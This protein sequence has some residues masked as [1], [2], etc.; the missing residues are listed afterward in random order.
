[1]KKNRM[2]ANIFFILLI[3]TKYTSISHSQS[4]EVLYFLDYCSTINSKYINPIYNPYKILSYES[5]YIRTDSIPNGKTLA[6][7]NKIISYAQLDT[8]GRYIF[9][10]EKSSSSVYRLEIDTSC[11]M[12]SDRTINE[13]ARE[14]GYLNLNPVLCLK[15]FTL[16]ISNN[17]KLKQ[18]LSWNPNQ[19]N[20]HVNKINHTSLGNFKRRMKPDCHSMQRS[21]FTEPITF[22][23]AAFIS[24]C[25]KRNPNSTIENQ[26]TKTLIIDTCQ[27]ADS[28]YYYAEYS[29][30]G[31][32]LFHCLIKF[33]YPY[34]SILQFRT[35]RSEQG[36]LRLLDKSLIYF[37]GRPLEYTMYSKDNAGI[38]VKTDWFYNNDGNVKKIE[39]IEQTKHNWLKKNREYYYTYYNK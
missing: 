18:T 14:V 16:L 19:D 3:L 23:P 6:V 30:S 31:R 15:G 21:F 33:T 39:S 22:L 34:Y 7:N 5:E 13:F 35:E 29:H 38:L 20:L 32:I 2:F 9:I 26:Y 8:N 11:T 24:Q 37:D 25:I 12:I 17:G 28:A 27:S 1:M 10:E 4:L 36:C